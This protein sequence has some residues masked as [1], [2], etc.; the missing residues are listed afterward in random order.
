MGM[1]LGN[2][3][4]LY[5][6]GCVLCRSPVSAISRIMGRWKAASLYTSILTT[7]QMPMAKCIPTMTISA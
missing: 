7:L 1:N 5:R 4:R 2:P 6:R 3:N